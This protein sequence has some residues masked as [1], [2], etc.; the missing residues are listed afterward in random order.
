MFKYYVINLVS[1]NKSINFAYES[2]GSVAQL[3]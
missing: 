3:D 2:V 1:N